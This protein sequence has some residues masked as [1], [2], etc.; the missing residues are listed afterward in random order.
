MQISNVYLFNLKAHACVTLA[1]ISI[2]VD[3]VHT[4]YQPNLKH[5][6]LNKLSMQHNQYM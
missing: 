4:V 3:V 1:K 5:N 6:S 2:S